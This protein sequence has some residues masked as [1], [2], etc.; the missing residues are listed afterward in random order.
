MDDFDTFKASRL[1]MDPSVRKM[2]EPQWQQAYAAHRSARKRATGSSSHETSKGKS[3]RR[4]RKSRSRGGSRLPAS[5]RAPTHLR[6][7]V[8]SSSAYGDA[9]LLIDVMAWVAISIVLLATLVKFLYYTNSAVYLSNALGA[10][11]QIVA[12]VSLRI[13]LHILIDIPD[14]ALREHEPRNPDVTVDQDSAG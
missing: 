2:T 13:T 14:I 10:A 3:V 5:L 8:R 7:E 9:R 6:D 11:L 1:K 12:I 4:K